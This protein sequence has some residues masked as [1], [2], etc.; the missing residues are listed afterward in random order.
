MLTRM[1]PTFA[2][3]YWT[4]VH[5]AQFGAQM[6]T[7]SPLASPAAT[8]RLGEAVHLLAED[9]IRPPQSLGAVDQRLAVAEPGDGRVEVGPDRLLEQRRLLRPAACDSAVSVELLAM[10]IP[11]CTSVWIPNVPRRQRRG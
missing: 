10:T 9:G 1:T 5:S 2:V 7:R 4:T 6:P 8:Q 3:A 11:F